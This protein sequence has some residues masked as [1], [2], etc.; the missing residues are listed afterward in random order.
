MMRTKLI[1]LFLYSTLLLLGQAALSQSQLD[2][3]SEAQIESYKSRVKDQVA[4]LEYLLN[5]LGNSQT[6][7]R[8]K[9][10]I[11]KES[12]QK[13]FINAEVQ[14]ED[15]LSENRKVITNKDIKAYLKDVDFFFKHAQFDFQVAEIE[16]L[17]HPQGGLYFLVT[18]NRTLR[19]TDLDGESVLNTAKRFIEVNLNEADDDLQIASI[20]TTKLNRDEALKEW[21]NQLS[22][23]WKLIF[24][25]SIQT[26]SDS[27]SLKN[28]VQIVE[29][30]SLDLSNTKLIQDIEPLNMLSNLTYLNLQNSSIKSITA[31]SSLTGLK[32]LNLSGTAIADLLYIKYAENIEQ[33]NISRTLITDLSPIQNFKEL[34]SLNLQSTAVVS[35]EVL[36]ELGALEVVD[37]SDTDFN[38]DDLS[39]LGSLKSLK[40]LN[41][42]K[43]AIT[44]MEKFEGA[45]LQQ[46]D[47]TFTGIDQLRAISNQRGLEILSISST[48][49]G[50]L[51]DLFEL[52][53]LSRVY[54]DNLFLS[55]KELSAFKNRR[56][57]VLL[58]VDSEGLTTWWAAL[59]IR[60]KHKL[61]YYLEGGLTS[62]PSK[63][64]LSK[65]ITRD[66]LDLSNGGIMQLFP[67]KKFTRL[68]YLD[69]SG[70]DLI[71]I[72]PLEEIQGLV[73][74]DLSNN[75]IFS[76]TSL[77]KLY[78]LHS[79]RL[80][81]NPL[82]METILE[83]SGLNSLEKLD[84]NAT[85]IE[86]SE[87]TTLLYSFGP[88]CLIRYDDA[89]IFK[90]WDDLSPSWQQIFLVQHTMDS[91]PGIWQLT[92]LLQKQTIAIAQEQ[93]AGLSALQ[94]FVILEVL[95]LQEVDLKDFSAIAE[96]KQLKVLSVNRMP[97][98]ALGFLSASEQLESLNLD[99]T[100]ID[101]LQ[102]LSNLVN[103][104]SLSV[105]ATPLRSL[106][107]IGYLQQLEYLN[108]AST[109]VLFINKLEALPNLRK[110]ICYNT[111]I[112]ENWIEK[113]RM[114]NSTCEI[115][116]Y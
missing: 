96:L 12:Y 81:G 108:L 39:Y 63:E 22:L 65:L 40:Q 88:T 115:M 50:S 10:V 82:N 37:L 46:L 11:I 76:V 55:E 33:L 114:Y 9:D 105:A 56:P 99:F 43:T 44:S 111:N 85:G 109:K 30:D 20:Y 71:S 34:K 54:A 3:F 26:S 7:Q 86:K 23:G 73:T 60:W 51:I 57:K 79:L 32:V 95:Y 58:V 67:I 74:L 38:N 16:A 36:L 70:N 64:A 92:Q 98:K 102:A 66:S 8:D 72:G 107:G 90:W 19:A 77:N 5:T 91:T 59:D 116:W 94:Q 112:R 53:Q 14:V 113:Y 1:F 62:E 25:Q 68:K 78:E 17:A 104:K 69:L 83:L 52:P 48:Q 87:V 80:A 27:I 28:L 18:T 93:I 24:R 29:L 13:I 106:K 75:K 61:E 42:S 45:Q 97:L 47:L 4:F 49:V 31:L 101:N 6:N 35:F 110:L 21:W 84:L 2:D 15:D 41:L 103:L 100:A 89:L